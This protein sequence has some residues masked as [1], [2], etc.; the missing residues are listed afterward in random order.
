MTLHSELSH[1]NIII[2]LPHNV[3]WVMHSYSK[4][5]HNKAHHWYSSYLKWHFQVQ[6]NIAQLFLSTQ[7][8]WDWRNA[9]H[10]GGWQTTGNDRQWGMTNSQTMTENGEW[11]T[12]RQWQTMGN[13]KQCNNVRQWG[14]TNNEILTDNGEWQTVRQWLTMGNDKQ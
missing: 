14:I 3:Q 13:D 2:L 1:C 7:S 10:N 6:N 11:P 5:R 9:A 4:S 8:K 12:M